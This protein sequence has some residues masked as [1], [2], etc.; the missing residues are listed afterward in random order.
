MTLLHIAGIVSLLLYY[1][2]EYDILLL[3]Y[4]EYDLL[5]II[6]LFLLEGVYFK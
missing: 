3:F 6:R 1:V 2:H 4:S 5:P